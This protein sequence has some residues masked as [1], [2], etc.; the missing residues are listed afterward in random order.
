MAQQKTSKLSKSRGFSLD[1]KLPNRYNLVTKYKTTRGGLKMY[2]TARTNQTVGYEVLF[3]H[4]C[5]CY[6]NGQD[7]ET[8][9]CSVSGTF[10]HITVVLSKFLAQS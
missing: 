9:S 5:T 8:V 1:F 3:Q 4:L 2:R 6:R 7:T 10:Y